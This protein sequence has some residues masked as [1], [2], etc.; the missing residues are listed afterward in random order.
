M[1]VEEKAKAAAD[2]A[3]AELK[4][5]LFLAAPGARKAIQAMADALEATAHEIE[6]LKIR[7][8]GDRGQV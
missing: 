7:I 8:G 6:I 4:H 2:M 5:P 3:R 1:T